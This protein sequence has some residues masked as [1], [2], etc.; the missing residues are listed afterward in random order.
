MMMEHGLYLHLPYC[1]SL[2]PYCAFAKAPL[3]RAEPERLLRSLRDEWE[4]AREEDGRWG[5]PRTIFLG[6]GTPT[7]LAPESLR[8]LLAWIGD[9]FDL[10]RVREWTA[11]ANPE[12]LTDEKLTVLR[13]GGVDRL[14]LGIQSLEPG[15]LRALGRIHSPAGALDAIARARRAAFTNISIDLMVAVPGET[16]EGVRRA[17]ETVVD[18]GVPHVSVYSLQVEEG[19]PLSAK[20]A[21]GA[22]DPPG[23]EVAAA[24]YEEIAAVLGGAGYLHYE[25]SNWALPGFESR[26][27]KGYWARR[28]YLGLG[29]GAHSFDGG[30]R[31]RNE[32]GVTRYYERV[33]EGSLPRDDRAALSARDE[34]E[35]RIMLGLR[36][37]RGLRRIELERL[38]GPVVT[39][40]SEWAARA[41][42]VRLDPPG[43]VR[44]TDR[45]LLL[46]QEISAE[47]L[48]RMSKAPP[49]P[50]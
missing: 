18:L 29:P 26:H 8:E 21:R 37:A 1:R 32:E 41:G 50:A 13:G 20:V 10:S 45:G 11:E 5:R 15:V 24:R 42:A 14:S 46:A 33:E 7:A 39:R 38:A 27:N 47:L 28:P 44:P 12:G 2:C 43:R 16:S 25:V 36:R 48:A 17:V 40:W 34:V 23:D 35:E 4:M 30:E 3:H 49:A 19:T 9:A 6:G 22:V 31:W